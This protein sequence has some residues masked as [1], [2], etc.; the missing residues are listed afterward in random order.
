LNLRNSPLFSVY[1]PDPSNLK[2]WIDTF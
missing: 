2:K 1:P